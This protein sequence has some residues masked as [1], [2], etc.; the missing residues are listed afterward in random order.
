MVVGGGAGLW[1]RPG[2]LH[3]EAMSPGQGADL[4]MKVGGVLAAVGAVVGAF[5]NSLTTCTQGGL[6]GPVS[7]SN[8][9]GE[10]GVDF[11]GNPAIVPLIA[12]GGFWGAVLG[13]L[14]GVAIGWL[15]PHTKR[16][17]FP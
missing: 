14:I 8:W 13:S 10:V 4:V 11:S 7:C 15:W 6:T 1:W 2:A 16:S 17:L 5:L 12:W 9:L 3:T